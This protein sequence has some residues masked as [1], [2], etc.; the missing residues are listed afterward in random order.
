MRLAWHPAKPLLSH[1]LWPGRASRS[2]PI[3]DAAQSGALSHRGN[4]IGCPAQSFNKG[5]DNRL[6]QRGNTLPLSDDFELDSAPDPRITFG[7]NGYSKGTILPKLNELKGEQVN[8]LPA[9]IN[10]SDYNE[11]WIWCKKFDVGLGVAR[12]K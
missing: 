2:I 4:Q 7:R 5:V 10:P 3:A 9:R 12:V 11:V 6:Q 8:K 1:R